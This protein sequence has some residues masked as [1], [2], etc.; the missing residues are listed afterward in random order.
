MKKL[1]VNL[2]IVAS[3]AIIFASCQ[4]E[5][6]L[7]SDPNISDP[8]A[9]TDIATSPSDHQIFVVYQSTGVPILYKDTVSK[10]PLTTVSLNYNLSGTA[11]SLRFVYLTNPADILAG[12]NFVQTQVLPH[13]TG[14]VKPYSV[15]LMDSVVTKQYSQ[16]L[17]K[18]VDVSLISY[19]GLKS[20]AIGNVRQISKMASDSLASYR[21]YVLAGMLSAKLNN[22]TY[23]PL[24]NNF[25]AVSANSYSIA[26]ANTTV[27]ENLGFISNYATPGSYTNAKPADL[28]NYLRHY[29]TMG[30]A[31][32]LAKYS[33]Y[34]LVTSKINY[35][36]QA[37]TTLGYVE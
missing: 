9:R 12:V 1:F 31:A 8:F 35:L 14:I 34:P 13:L 6:A 11:S 16:T 33:T 7:K 20:L 5:Q 2:L 17:F 28:T 22:V 36:K 29:L 10:S 37:L 27:L 4:K 26:I 24:L 25:Y 15:L 23:T 3:S 21:A 32:M 19:L 18:Q 30:S